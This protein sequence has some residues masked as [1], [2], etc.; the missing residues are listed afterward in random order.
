MGQ[1]AQIHGCTGQGALENKNDSLCLIWASTP[2]NANP[3]TQMEQ[4]VGIGNR[5]M[6]SISPQAL[7]CMSGMS[8]L[9][10]VFLQQAGQP[11]KFQKLAEFQSHPKGAKKICKMKRDVT[12]H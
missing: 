4:A 1:E 9:Q 5:Q 6:D 2:Q 3:K 11:P 8:R 7:A 12:W 10:F